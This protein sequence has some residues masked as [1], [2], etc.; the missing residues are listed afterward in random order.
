MSLAIKLLTP[1]SK[2]IMHILS[3]DGSIRQ[4]KISKKCP[5]FYGNSVE[6]KDLG[7]KN[8]NFKN[9]LLAPEGSNGM[10]G[11][12]YNTEAHPYQAV[13]G[14]NPVVKSKSLNVFGGM[15][16]TLM[17]DSKGR[18]MCISGNV[19]GFR[20]LLMDA[21]TLEV[22]AETRLPQRASTKEFFKTLDFTKISTDTSGGA[23][24]HL[25]DGDRPII[26]NSHNVIQIYRLDESGAK[27]KW[28]VEKQ[29][30]IAPHLPQGSYIQDALPDYDGNI[31]FVTR[32]GQVGFVDKSDK[33]HITNLNS[34]EEIHNTIAI[35][36][37][38]VFLNSNYAQY[39]FSINDNGEPYPVWRTEYDRG[40]KQKPG[41]IL[42]GSG[43][44]PTLLDVPRSDGSIARLVGI[45]DNADD[46]VHVVIFDRDTG[47][48]ISQT[49]VFES[50]H[51]VTE[52]SLIAYDRSFIIENNYTD[53]GSAFLTKN[54]T[55]YPGVARVEVNA[56]VTDSKV[57]WTSKE[58]SPTTV[59]KL[60]TKSG[61]V[62][63]YTREINN[64]IPKKAVAWYLTAIDYE[65]GETKFKV[66]TG[67]GRRWNNSYAPITIGPNKT[68]YVGVF[69]GVV[70]VKD[71]E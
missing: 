22:L 50:G 7:N 67:T 61:L 8:K 41:T 66:F 54:P 39:K 15:I 23:Y 3:S 1:I 14:K 44:T 20:L 56:D 65:T 68:V 52:N 63:L 36:A 11:D 32:Y 40:T 6:H 64:D 38:G 55:S 24:C 21:D 69:N 9:P 12:S 58:A 45:S 17:F 53:T 57:V 10:H 31:W 71:S 2:L 47:K 19:V 35:S 51:S 46:R 42:Q 48:I 4:P 49:P 18:I 60:S 27:P 29:W 59:P 25:L 37:D 30:N 16:A 28:E 13:I 70:A 43:T 5:K 26:G 34:N 62:Y 33:V